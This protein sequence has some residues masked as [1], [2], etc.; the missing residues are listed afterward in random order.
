MIYPPPCQ[1]VPLIP[2]IQQYRALNIANVWKLAR[3]GSSL[4][5]V[6]L[7]FF[8]CSL[9][10]L[11]FFPLLPAP[12]LYL[13]FYFFRGRSPHF[14]LL[15][16]W[17]HQS[18]VGLVKGSS[19]SP[20]QP[21]HPHSFPFNKARNGSLPFRKH[22]AIFNLHQSNFDSHSIILLSSSNVRPSHDDQVGQDGW[23]QHSF[24]RSF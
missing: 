21:T 19:S 9:L 14:L 6:I 24:R 20:N 11:F 15:N 16:L 5:S 17:S 4:R 18:Q 13:L 8:V 1:N 7:L 2:F 23:L 22:H 12:S 10:F 3:K